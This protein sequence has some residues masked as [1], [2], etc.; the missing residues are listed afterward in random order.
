[1]EYPIFIAARYVI[2]IGVWHELLLRCVLPFYEVLVE[3]NILNHCCLPKLRIRNAVQYGG[4]HVESN[5]VIVVQVRI[6][7]HW[8]L[9]VVT[10]FAICGGGGRKYCCFVE[11]RNN[12]L[13]NLCCVG[14]SV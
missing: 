1:M 9:K 5:I 4:Y 8:F 3:K 13:I 2:E 10:V 11:W 12:C 7:M 14:Y 6:V